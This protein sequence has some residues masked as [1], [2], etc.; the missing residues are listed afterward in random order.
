M[1]NTTVARSLALSYGW[2]TKVCQEASHTAQPAHPKIW[3]LLT[4]QLSGRQ[5][6]KAAKMIAEKPAPAV[7]LPRNSL[8]NRS[9]SK[10]R[11]GP[12]GWPG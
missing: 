4:G 9:F 7:L 11:R 10:T 8:S 12:Q 6:Q 3:P 2:M 1:N 5:P